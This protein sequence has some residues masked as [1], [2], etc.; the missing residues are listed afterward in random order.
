V[1]VSQFST[2]LGVTEP[3]I[4]SAIRTT[5]FC[6]LSVKASSCSRA[7]AIEIC[8]PG[9]TNPPRTQ[10]CDVVRQRRLLASSSCCAPMDCYTKYPIHTTTNLRQKVV[11]SSLP[12]WPPATLMLKSLQNLLHEDLR[13]KTTVSPIVVQIQGME[14]PK[15][16]QIGTDEG[17]MMP[18]TRSG[19]LKR[20][21]FGA[22]GTPKR[23]QGHTTL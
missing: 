1:S 4:R 19:G 21:K 17:R 14:Q 7:Y 8:E 10:C 5:L 6:R 12:F 2:T 22:P 9:F 23:S 18:R 20:I 15:I 13:K 11:A 3:L 16:A